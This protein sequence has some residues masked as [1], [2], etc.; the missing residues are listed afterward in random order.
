[1]LGKHLTSAS[2]DWVNSD[3]IQYEVINAQLRGDGTEEDGEK[4]EEE[5]ESLVAGVYER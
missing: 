1:M 3:S 5:S 2:E 4:E